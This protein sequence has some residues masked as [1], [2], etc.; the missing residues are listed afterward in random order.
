LKNGVSGLWQ[1]SF[2]SEGDNEFF[3]KAR[4]TGYVEETARTAQERGEI[5]QIGSEMSRFF[6]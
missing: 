3:R 6:C 2:G 4:H 1:I 5:V